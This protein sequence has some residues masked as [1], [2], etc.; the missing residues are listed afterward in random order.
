VQFVWSP[1]SAKFQN[2]SLDRITMTVSPPTFREGIREASLNGEYWESTQW[3]LAR[4][5]Q[6]H[7][8]KTGNFGSRR[9]FLGTG[10]IQLDETDLN[11]AVSG[12]RE[13]ETIPMEAAQTMQIE[14]ASEDP[15]DGKEFPNRQELTVTRILRDT[16]VGKWVKQLHNFTC[17][18]YGPRLVTPPVHM[19]KPVTSSLWPQS[20]RAASGG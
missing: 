20:G 3:I 18:I 7:R 19:R 17:Q 11:Q 15:P 9:S 2:I 4:I 10:R 1:Y 14:T 16:K 5:C 12:S 6:K 8:S 13:R